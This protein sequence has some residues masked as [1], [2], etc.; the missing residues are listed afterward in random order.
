M[1]HSYFGCWLLS[2]CPFALANVFPTFS[3]TLFSWFSLLS[4]PYRERIKNNNY[5]A[6]LIFKT[7]NLFLYWHVVVTLLLLP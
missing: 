2:L 3:F 1:A 4:S 6:T 5:S 7:F